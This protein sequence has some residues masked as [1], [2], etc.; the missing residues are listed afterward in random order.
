MTRRLL[1]I[2]A[3]LVAWAAPAGAQSDKR[4]IAI[5][6]PQGTLG[7]GGDRYGSADSPVMTK[8]ARVVETMLTRMGVPYKVILLPDSAGGWSR[9]LGDVRDT[10]EADS[11]HFRKNGC[12]G[13]ISFMDNFSTGT[14]LKTYTGE[15]GEVFTDAEGHTGEQR[16]SPLD[17]NWGI[18]GVIFTKGTGPR[19]AGGLLC[20]I[21]NNFS[22]TG[23]PRNR[24][25][26]A[27]GDS[28]STESDRVFIPEP[29]EAA[30]F[31]AI[32]KS[33]DY[34]GDND[35]S[36]V[37]AWAY[38]TVSK[39]CLYYSVASDPYQDPKMIMLGV[40]DVLNRAGYKPRRKLNLH[41]DLDHPYPDLVTTVRAPTDSL[42]P[43][44]DRQSWRFGG[45]VEA[46]A[47]EVRGGLNPDNE[48]TAPIWKSRS[49]RWPGDP[50]SHV[51]MNF[52]PDANT[53]NLS[54]FA[55]SATKRDRWNQLV[56]AI[57]DTIG[58]TPA[59][60]YEKTATF[61]DNNIYFPD[62]YIMA[63]G[64]YRDIRS[65]GMNSNQAAGLDSIGAPKSQSLRRW[66]QVPGPRVDYGT[67]I[68]SY[69]LPY[70]YIEP[71]TNLP[72]WVHDSVEHPN[73]GDS[74]QVSTT[75][76][77]V[78]M[79]GFAS[80][81][82]SGMCRMAI[83]DGGQYWHPDNNV[84]SGRFMS[85]FF[86]RFTYFYGRV[87]NILDVSPIYRPKTPR[88]AGTSRTSYSDHR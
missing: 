63:S 82:L 40:A 61:P 66:Q 47:F 52:Y 31:E 19:S 2:A 64:G 22:L 81:N 27:N 23:H 25:L 57:R 12:M 34:A 88:I 76:Y 39:N 55:D 67:T 7:K 11:T 8:P 38:G 41:I 6:A 3:L 20:G 85:D 37:L 46:M 51:F 35:S 83:F 28:L 62:L 75:D 24:A 71:K 84:T 58:H 50:H 13:W 9:Q 54:T 79:E 18:P 77:S 26:F 42:M 17:G 86:R 36:L 72:L 60:G 14:S 44:F 45:A 1:L 5:F 80:R 29:T 32:I 43:Y 65:K 30:N 48:T 49:W 16:G 73:S 69:G 10:D 15:I 33:P 4:W 70:M 21:T 59:R 56:L 74:T 53:W 78:S 68:N 87:K